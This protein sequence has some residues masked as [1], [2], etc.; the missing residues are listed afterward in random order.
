MVCYIQNSVLSVNS[1]IA[2]TDTYKQNS[3]SIFGRGYGAHPTSYPV[4][5]GDSFSGG[6]KAGA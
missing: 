4:G 2:M 6:K 3:G 5:T 1:F